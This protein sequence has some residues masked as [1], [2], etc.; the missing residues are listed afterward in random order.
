MTA[1]LETLD[2]RAAADALLAEQALRTPTRTDG[3]VRVRVVPPV[4]DIDDEDRDGAGSLI[5]QQ[6]IVDYLAAVAQRAVKAVRFGQVE[7]LAD[8][9]VHPETVSC[10]RCAAFGATHTQTLAVVLLEI[11]AASN[12]DEEWN[13]SGASDTQL[14]SRLRRLAVSAADLE[15]LFGPRWAEVMLTGLRAEAADL[16]AMDC[17]TRGQDDKLRV[18]EMIHDPVAT[19]QIMAAYHL[20]TIVCPR[21]S[22]RGDTSADLKRARIARRFAVGISRVAQG[23]TVAWL[24]HLPA[25]PL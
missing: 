7:V 3:M 13:N 12:T 15:A 6:L 14:I 22:R 24:D 17:L 8:D 10:L 20:G 16:E 25:P 23:E 11:L 1:A 4:R 21:E 5:S 18:S 19:R 9:H 2:V